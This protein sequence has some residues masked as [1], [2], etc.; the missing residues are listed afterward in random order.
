MSTSKVKPQVR[1]EQ[2]VKLF[3]GLAQGE[4][5]VAHR[6][7][8]L[9]PLYATADLPSAAGLPDGVCVIDTDV[10]KIKYTQSGSW[11]ALN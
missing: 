11:V 4:A 6:V 3:D 7:S 10:N 1:P 8:G 9:L 2:K 5:G